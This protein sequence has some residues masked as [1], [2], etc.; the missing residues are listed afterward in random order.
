MEWLIRTGTTLLIV[1]VG[2]ILGPVLKKGIIKLSKNASD[3]GA[4]TFIGSG[5]SLLTKIAG[6]IIALSQLGVN[7]NVIVGA[8]SA[9]GLGISLALKD[10]MANVAGGM[11]ILFTRPFMVGDYI[12]V[13]NKEGTVVRIELMFTVVKTP[14][15]QEIIVPNS[16][17]VQEII[18]NYSRDEYRRISL[19]FPVSISTDV[20]ALREICIDILKKDSSVIMEKP[21]E[22]IIDKM[23]ERSIWMGVYCWTKFDEYWDTYHRLYDAIQKNRFT[24]TIESP[25]ESVQIL[26][27]R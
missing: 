14:S 6:I 3:K 22:V 11:Q 21:Y 8:F 23:D 20:Q 2:F 10:N 17:M 24:Q 16:L 27:K 26:D 7:T 1:A 5:V 9:A 19:Q 15:A 12:S 4:L 25:Y 18:I 13:E